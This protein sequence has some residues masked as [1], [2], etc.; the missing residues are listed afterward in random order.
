[1]KPTVNAPCPML[2]NRMI[3]IEGGRFCKG[4]NKV[5]VDCTQKSQEEIQD[6][7]EQQGQALCGIF[8]K[9]QLNQRPSS[10]SF[11]WRY[12][13]AVLLAIVGFHMKPV[14][15]TVVTRKG[16]PVVMKHDKSLDCA[17]SLNQKKTHWRKKMW[18]RKKRTYHFRTIG[19][20][21]F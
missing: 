21:S 9:E 1:M 5:V 20:P 12:A 8:R 6:L 4:C 13:A 17:S 10:L 2:M 18:F 3:P 19:C 11:K 16:H 14:A 7:M 15:Q